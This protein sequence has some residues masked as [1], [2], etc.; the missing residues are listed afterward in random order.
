MDAPYNEQFYMEAEM[1]NLPAA[2]KIVPLIM[3]LLKPHS[4]VDVGCGTGLWLKAFTERGITTV[5]GIDGNWVKSEKLVIPAECFEAADLEKPIRLGGKRF[6]LAVCLEVAEHLPIQAA[7][8][9]VESLTLL[10]PVVLFSAAIPLQGGSR[11]VNEQWP[12]YWMSLFERKGFVPVDCLRKKVWSD[13]D[14]PFYY[15]QNM[16][17]Y[18]KQA[19]LRQY[20]LLAKE[21]EAGND[22]ALSLVHPK[23]YL[24]YAEKWRLISPFLGKLPEPFVRGIRRVLRRLLKGSQSGGS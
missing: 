3:N 6:D 7:E 21:R 18:V 22:R 14:V 16:F 19:D 23:M 5:H 10:A 8:T 1:S 24:L 13:D 12:E 11:H 20:P 15:A 4:V 2:R 17:I 9:L